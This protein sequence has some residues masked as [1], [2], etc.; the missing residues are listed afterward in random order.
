MNTQLIQQLLAANY[1]FNAD[2]MSI[3]PL[4]NGLI[5]TTW[6]V[7][8]NGEPFVFQ[9]IND[10]VFTDPHAIDNNLDVIV[11]YLQ[12]YYPNYLF[13]APEKT[14]SGNTM[15]DT[16]TGEYYRMFPFVPG[17]H[18]VDVVA[19]PEQAYEAALMFGGFTRRLAGLHTD[20]LRVTLPRFHDLPFRYAQFQQSI[21]EGSTNRIKQA[22]NLVKV[23]TANATI[24]STYEKMQA[25]RLLRIRPTHHDT[26]ISN[27][28]FDAQEKGLCVIDLD[29]VMPGYFISDTGDMLRTMLCPVSEEEIDLT[30]IEV[31]DEYYRAI[32]TGYMEAMN[33]ELDETERHQFFYSGIYMLYMQG[34]RF[35][36]DY[37][38]D[39]IY[40]KSQY[41]EHN[42]NRAKNEFTLLQRLQEKEKKYQKIFK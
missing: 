5:N 17:S 37:F 30:R 41:P 15:I 1:G 24:V 25:A 32:Y 27:V 35:L 13:A 42:F 3:M 11:E 40:Y 6:K 19:T 22:A 16:G 10:A 39:D 2:K 38:N 7:M 26:K 33:A 28:L 4:G 36:T 21:K 20:K 14:L 29:T 34:L 31:R 8:E 12:Q 23:V 9:K 18:S